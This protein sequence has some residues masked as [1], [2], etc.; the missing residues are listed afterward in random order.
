[1]P[2]K[3]VSLEAKTVTFD[4]D[5]QGENLVFDL[6]EC[7]QDTIVRLALHGAS[8]KIGDSYAGAKSKAD[9]QNMTVPAYARQQA[10]GVITNLY[11]GDFNAGGGG[12]GPR[13]SMLSQALAEV[14]GISEAEAIAKIA[15]ADDEVKK[16]LK[17]HPQIKTVMARLQAEAAAARA[18]KLEEQAGDEAEAP[19]LSALLA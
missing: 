19:D 13:S 7:D 3:N 14:G 15:E 8:Q 2:S 6:N 9:E 18:K 12:G 4:F 5:D 10:D 1:M 17:K 16:A 11:N